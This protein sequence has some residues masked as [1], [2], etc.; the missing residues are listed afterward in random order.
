LTVA[1]C[2]RHESER[3]YFNVSFYVFTA[4]QDHARCILFLGGELGRIFKGD[5][6]ERLLEHVA[7]HAADGLTIISAWV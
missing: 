5:K 6:V 4:P 7:E 1:T 2:L 3:T